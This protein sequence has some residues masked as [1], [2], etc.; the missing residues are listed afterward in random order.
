MRNG[1]VYKLVMSDFRTKE[2]V[3]GLLPTVTLCGNY[4]RVGA[5]ATSGDGI[6]TAVKQLT[7]FYPAAEFCEV[8]MGFPP[9]W[10]ELNAAETP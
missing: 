3:S 2:T 10:T 8:M 6:A 9:G 7:G 4:N 1:I 5:S